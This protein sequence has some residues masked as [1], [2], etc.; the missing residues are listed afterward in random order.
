MEAVS[1]HGG[2]EHVF[3]VQEITFGGIVALVKNSPML[4]TFRAA[5]VEALKEDEI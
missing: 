3:I 1:V 2:L 5:V 4:I